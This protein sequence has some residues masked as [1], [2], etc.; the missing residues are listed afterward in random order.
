MNS[1]IERSELKALGLW[2]DEDQSGVVWQ[3]RISMKIIADTHSFRDGQVA[4]PCLWN[5][6]S[7]DCHLHTNDHTL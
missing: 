6:L 7:H 2:P 4:E 1:K 3:S 5:S